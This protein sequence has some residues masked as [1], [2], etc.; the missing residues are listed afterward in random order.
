MTKQEYTAIE[1]HEGEGEGA[2]TGDLGLSSQ[3][4]TFSRENIQQF[5]ATARSRTQRAAKKSFKVSKRVSSRFNLRTHL[6]ALILFVLGGV[7]PLAFFYQW[8]D[9]PWTPMHIHCEYVDVASSD[10]AIQGLVTIDGLVVTLPFWAAKL[11]DTTWDLFVGRGLQ[12]LAAYLSYVVFTKAMLRAIE[13]TPTPYR[14]FSGLSINGVGIA[15]LFSL[16]GDLRRHRTKRTTLL[17]TWVAVSSFYVLSISTL[18]SAMTGYVS[19]LSAYIPTSDA[20]QL[21]PYDKLDTGYLIRDGERVGVQNGS[22]SEATDELSLMLNNARFQRSQCGL[23]WVCNPIQSENLTQPT[24]NCMFPC[25][26][27]FRYPGM[28]D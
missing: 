3:R 16:L 23:Q 9:D 25:Y 27:L 22:C 15:T 12:F 17:F 21:M 18:F 20:G 26:T 7:L 6:L 28:L 13:Q 1:L 10:P 8:V 4:T 19:A 11:L 2:A 14:T 5:S 24:S